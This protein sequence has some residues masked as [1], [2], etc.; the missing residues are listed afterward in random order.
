VRSACLALAV[1]VAAAAA[2]CGGSGGGDPIA[3]AQAKLAAKATARASIDAV[4]KSDSAHCDMQLDFD[5]GRS[6]VACGPMAGEPPVEMRTIG[7]AM[8]VRS[9]REAK[10]FKSDGGADD[11][12][13]V[14]PRRLLE[15]LQHEAR[16]VS[17]VGKE[18]VQGVE[19]TRYH[20]VDSDG[21]PMEVWVDGD[22][23]VRRM[24]AV[25]SP[26][27]A[28]EA[29]ITVEFSDFGAPVDI[30]PPPADEVDE[31]PEDPTQRLTT[32]SEPAPG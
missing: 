18:T 5:R 25:D 22:G 12:A 11:L 28:D 16:E 27:A 13:Q 19:T 1:A 24:K 26:G 8:Y 3:S 32:F 2:A 15:Q 14:D 23:L 21:A 30:E 4:M 29:R 10:W 6:A 9:G 20:L 31:L 7:G 17:V